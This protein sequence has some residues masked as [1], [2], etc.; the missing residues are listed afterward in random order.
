METY[1]R[2]IPLTSPRNWVE[3]LTCFPPYI[4]DARRQFSGSSKH[5]TFTYCPPYT[6]LDRHLIKAD[7]FC[8]INT[9]ESSFCFLVLFW[10]NFWINCILNLRSMARWHQMTTDCFPRNARNTNTN[11]HL[12]TSRVS[13]LWTASITNSSLARVVSCAQQWGCTWR[14]PVLALYGG[15]CC[16]HEW[17]AM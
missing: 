10:V 3:C 12:C 5:F 17:A 4:Y 2:T 1:T 13:N 15:R 11:R 9:I 16:R 7:P 6:T 8:Q 14:F